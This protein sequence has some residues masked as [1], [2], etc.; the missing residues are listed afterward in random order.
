[1]FTCAIAFGAAAEDGLEKVEDVGGGLNA[2]FLVGAE[3]DGHGAIVLKGE[4]IDLIDRNVNRADMRLHK[5][6]EGI[7]A[8]GKLTIMIGRH[9]G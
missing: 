9:A 5:L 6:E 1:M 8:V 7:V 2:D 4:R 3:T